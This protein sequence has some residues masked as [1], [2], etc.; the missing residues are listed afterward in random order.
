MV[1]PSQLL[2]TFDFFSPPAPFYLPQFVIKFK[3]SNIAAMHRHSLIRLL[4][5]LTS[6]FYIFIH[7]LGVTQLYLGVPCPAL[8]LLLFWFY[9]LYMKTFKLFFLFVCMCTWVSLCVCHTIFFFFFSKRNKISAQMYA[10]LYRIKKKK[11]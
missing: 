7:T 3:L 6:L 1:A 2:A 11:I 9:K 5:C 8:H 4:T 10:K